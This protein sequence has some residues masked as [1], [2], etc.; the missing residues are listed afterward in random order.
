MTQL[1]L[2]VAP[3]AIVSRRSGRQ[4]VVTSIYG[5]M[6]RYR[7]LVQSAGPLTD[8]EAAER[9]RVPLSAVN[10]ARGDWQCWAENHGIASPVV[11][12]DRVRQTWGRG[13]CTSRVRWGWQA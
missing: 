12:V 6:A 4:R 9:L 13:R 7:D 11:A 8:H 5:R 1:P 10:A 2:T 3:S